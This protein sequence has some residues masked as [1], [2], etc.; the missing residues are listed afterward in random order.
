MFHV[1][2]T[3]DNGPEPEVT[4]AVLDMLAH[5]G[6]RATFF[7]VGEKLA[8]DGR[9]RL[10]ERAA[11]EGHWIGNHTWSHSVPLGES[12]AGAPEREIGETQRLIGDLAHPDRLFRPFGRGGAIGPHLLNRAAAEYLAT[13][14]YTCL[15]WNAIPRD[16]ADPEGWVDRALG[17]C[18]AQPWTLLVLHD[19]PTGAMAHLERFIAAVH[20]R[21]GRFRQDFPPD[22]VS[23]RRGAALPGLEA[24]VAAGEPSAPGLH[25]KTALG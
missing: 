2:L 18:A 23:M 1:T 24:I 8:R 3:F 14:G 15:L 11:A 25:R 9:R 17:Q 4:P 13:G 22:C 19:L 21:G 6:V 16:W 5:T 20:Q 7:V 10:A 12:G